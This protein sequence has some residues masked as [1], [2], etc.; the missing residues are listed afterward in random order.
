M[1]YEK[2]TYGSYIYRSIIRNGRCME[3]F[4]HD[5]GLFIYLQDSALWCV[6]FALIR[7]MDGSSQE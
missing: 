5:N 3:Y 1:I 4:I 7:D 6:C 2:K